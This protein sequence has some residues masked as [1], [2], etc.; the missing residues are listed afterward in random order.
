MT[1]LFSGFDWVKVSKGPIYK[2]VFNAS[3][4]WWLKFDVIDYTDK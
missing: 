2:S 3:D 4:S 1:C